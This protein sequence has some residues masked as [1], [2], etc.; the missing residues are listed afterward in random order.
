VLE[1]GGICRVDP[2]I[3]A[4]IRRHSQM[5]EMLVSLF[6]GNIERRGRRI[7][8]LALHLRR[9]QPARDTAVT[10]P[11]VPRWSREVEMACRPSRIGAASKRH[12]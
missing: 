6:G 4:H 3:S 8:D 11:A 12:G 10:G 1:K 7:P 9:P 2:A 5:T